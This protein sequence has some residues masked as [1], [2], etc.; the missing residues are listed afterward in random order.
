[1]P[2]VPNPRPIL[3]IH[4]TYRGFKTQHSVILGLSTWGTKKL[5]VLME[6]FNN[7]AIEA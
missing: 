2:M 1:M 4:V 3:I 5:Q 7:Q 6:K